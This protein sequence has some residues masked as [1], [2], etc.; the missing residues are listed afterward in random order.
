MAAANLAAEGEGVRAQQEIRGLRGEEEGTDGRGPRPARGS[1]QLWSACV[2]AERWVPHRD[3]ART[4]PP[5]A[6]S[7]RCDTS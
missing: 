4:E 1:L 3:A 7:T 6:D 5:A 2:S